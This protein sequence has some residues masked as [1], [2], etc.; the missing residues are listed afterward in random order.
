[1]PQ[2]IVLLFVVQFEFESLCSNLNLNVFVFLLEKKWKAFPSHSLGFQPIRPT[3]PSLSFLSFSFLP[4]PMEPRR[5]IL[6][7]R[8]S[9][10]PRPLS[11][12][13]RRVGPACRGCPPPRARPGLLQSPAAPRLAGLPLARTPRRSAPPLY[14]RRTA[15]GN[16]SPIRA[17]ALLPQT[18]ARVAIGAAEL[19]LDADPPL[20]RLSS[21]SRRPG[22]PRGIGDARRPILSPYPSLSHPRGLTRI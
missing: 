10:P 4:R 1:M 13:H 17:A 2:C 20:R 12:S 19:G 3:P 11:R 7:S 16:P 9:P 21:T 18:L 6:L 22:A 14:K 8:S 5:P 15:P